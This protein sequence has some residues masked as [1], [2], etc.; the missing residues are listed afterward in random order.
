MR[1]VPEVAMEKP[2]EIEEELVQALAGLLS[3]AYKLHK[4][5][6][7]CGERCEDAFESAELALERRRFLALRRNGARTRRG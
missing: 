6:H 5:V 4:G 3:L 1:S 2:E 7:I